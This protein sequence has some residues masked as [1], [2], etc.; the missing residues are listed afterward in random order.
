VVAVDLAVRLEEQHVFSRSGKTLVIGSGARMPDG[1]GPFGVLIE[2][3]SLPPLL[4]HDRPNGV[5]YERPRVQ[6][7]VK[8]RD[9]LAIREKAIEA[10][11]AL[12]VS[13]TE[14]NGTPYTYIRP[15]Q[16]PF[17]LPPDTDGRLRVAF[18]VECQKRP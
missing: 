9:G 6:M 2:S 3:F 11:D 16:E 10:R 1:D 13:D 7:V 8:G 4:T 14:I 5:A 12:F 18:N 17:D 15:L